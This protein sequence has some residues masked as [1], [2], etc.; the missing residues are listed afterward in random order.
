MSVLAFA[1]FE[2]SE[3]VLCLGSPPGDQLPLQSTDFV[4]FPCCQAGA[5]SVLAKCEPLGWRVFLLL[6]RV[7]FCWLKQFSFPRCIILWAFR[8]AQCIML[9]PQD[10]TCL[11]PESPTLPWHAHT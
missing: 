2:Q 4:A 3:S 6:I 7:R 8:T 5:W 1:Y 11:P 10:A 9:T